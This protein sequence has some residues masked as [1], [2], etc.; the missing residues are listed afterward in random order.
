MSQPAKPI[1]KPKSLVVLHA[2]ILGLPVTFLGCEYRLFKKGDEV[3]IGD[4][5]FG[6]VEAPYWLS[7]PATRNGQSCY[8]GVNDA[9]TLTSFLA[10][11]E[12][13][14]DE[15]VALLAA[16]IALNSLPKPVRKLRWLDDEELDRI[17]PQPVEQ[18]E[19]RLK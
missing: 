8:L 19:A 5:Q 4:N 17:T 16:N 6:T 7:T 9:F 3:Q 11:A 2:L 12:R 13:L 14:S 1:S 15:E 18:L 10:C